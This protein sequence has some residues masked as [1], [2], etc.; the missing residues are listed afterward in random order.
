[1]R[2]RVIYLAA[3]NSRRF[4]SNKLLYE[5]D[6]RPLFSHLLERLICICGRH[7]EW[8]VIV[9]TQYESIYETAR[10]MGARCVLSPKSRKGASYSVR[11]GLRAALE[12]GTEQAEGEDRT[13]SA[14]E[15]ADACAFFVADQPYLTEE[16]AE[17]FL[18]EMERKRAGLGCAA[19]GGHRGNP[20][21]FSRQYFAELDGL[22][23]DRGGKAVLNAHPEEI[24]SFPVSKDRELEDID[25]PG[26][27][28]KSACTFSQR[29]IE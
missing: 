22:T 26:S 28:V 14:C 25:V 6:G 29:N 2:V 24:L 7:R 1:M 19:C 13:G 16:S 5:V 10:E 8:E 20:A 23:G 4:G 9:V 3:G 21:W 12:A 15:G 18:E 27:I 11:A 17:G